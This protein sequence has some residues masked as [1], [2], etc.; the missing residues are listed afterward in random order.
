VGGKE[1]TPRQDLKE[2]YSTIEEAKADMTGLWALGY[3][4]DKGLLKDSLG[5]GAA[6]ERKL[7][8]TFLASC[9]RTLH[10]GLSSSH[11]RGMAIQ[12]NY[13][14]DKGAFVSHG[15]GTFSVDF[16]KIK[17]AVADL[18]REFL[19]IEATGD[20]ARAKAMMA[21]YVV[22]RPDVQKALDKMKA[23][24]NDIRPA[25]VTATALTDG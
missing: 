4:M 20:Y 3:M 2:T 6:A 8:N 14:L 16:K 11:A 1:S 9:F 25:F 17:G 5:Q 15:D 7:Y 10:F 19:T 18:D 12:V 13:L 23:V 24:P 21:K 22:I